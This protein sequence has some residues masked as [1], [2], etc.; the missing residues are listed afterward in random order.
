MASRRLT[1]ARSDQVRQAL[2]DNPRTQHLRNLERYLAQT[3]AGME[4]KAEAKRQA[5][6]RCR[7]ERDDEVLR[8]FPDVT[9][10]EL[11]ELDE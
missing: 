6:T 7:D 8:E 5:I 1:P 4:A 10:D 3:P 11:L 2:R 9:R